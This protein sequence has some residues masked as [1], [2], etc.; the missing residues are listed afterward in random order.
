VSTDDKKPRRRRGRP[1][2]YDQGTALDAALR[3]F[4]AKGYSATSLDDLTDAMQMSRPSVYAGFGNK[5]AVYEAAVGHYVATIGS[6][7][8]RP[9]VE[10]PTLRAG[11][12]GFYAAVIDVVTG[13]HGPL[14]CSGA[15]TMPAE[16]GD[17]HQAREHLAQ[18]LASLDAAVLARMRAAQAAGELPRKADPVPLAQMTTSLML[19]LS[20]RARAGTSRRALTRL[21]RDFVDL[22]APVK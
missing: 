9:L 4:W 1:R 5:K 8:L 20:I 18:V 2:A 10:E 19:A 7:Y 12:L 17:S 6:R 22:L 15:C 11:L 13:K 14:G 21:A 3:T 16:A